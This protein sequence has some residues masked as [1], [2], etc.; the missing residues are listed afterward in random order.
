MRRLRFVIVGAS[1]TGSLVSEQLIRSHAGSVVPVDP[2]KIERKNLNRILHSTVKDAED[3]LSKVLRLEQ[4]ARAIGFDVE[5]VPLSTSLDAPAV[6]REV[7]ASDA[8]FG[9]MDTVDGR[10]LLNRICTFYL[11]PFVDV[12]V[13]L[14]A[15]GSGGVE[16][17]CGAIHY[18]QPGRSSFFTRN[19]FTADDVFAA[20]MKRRD[21][22]EYQKR[23]EQ[24]YIRGVAEDRPAVMPVNMVYAGLAVMEFFARVHRYR[25]D[26]NADYAYTILGL[27]QG[28][29]EHG[30]E[31]PDCPSLARYVGR[32][33]MAPLLDMPDYTEMPRAA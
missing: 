32:G 16:Q 7:S 6:I 15:D 4:S 23:V 2:D 12:G 26:G 25:L 28:I 10:A 1:G 8:A 5:I 22:A 33:D 20:A 14:D 13:R 19:V 11:L 17:I 18:F 21:P 30:P 29:L 24:K 27:S 31:G 9:C 3:G